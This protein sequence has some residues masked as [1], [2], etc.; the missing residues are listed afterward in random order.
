M[1]FMATVSKRYSIAVFMGVISGVGGGVVR[2][3][4]TGRVPILFV[5]QIYGIAGLIGAIV[6]V[7]FDHLRTVEPVKVWVPMA[8]VVLVRAIA[9]RYDLHLPRASRRN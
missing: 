6:F 9:V 5:G 3:V 8:I 4:F 1:P 7:V 2:D